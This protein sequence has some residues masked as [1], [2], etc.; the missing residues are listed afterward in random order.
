MKGRSTW[1]L[2]ADPSLAIPRAWA[3]EFI[4]FASSLVAAVTVLAAGTSTPAPGGWWTT[5][6]VGVILGAAL[7][8]ILLVPRWQAEWLVYLAQAVMLAAYVDYR[9][10][11]PQ[12]LAFDAI[13]FT[14][15]GYLDLGIAEVLERLE[16]KTYARPA[17]SS[18]FWYRCS[19]SCS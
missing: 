11:F 12:S 9:L 14:L 10:A 17:R 18:H 1:A 6:G 13:V 15:L 4:A 16:L 5:V 7:L 19:P 2:D 3:V 8:H